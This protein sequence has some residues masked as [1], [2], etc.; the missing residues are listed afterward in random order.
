MSHF[1]LSLLTLPPAASCSSDVSFRFRTGLWHILSWPGVVQC[2]PRTPCILA[3]VQQT[4]E[5]EENWIKALLTR[6]QEGVENPPSGNI[7][8]GHWSWPTAG[9]GKG[10]EPLAELGDRKSQ[11]NELWLL[12]HG[13]KTLG[14]QFLRGSWKPG[15]LSSVFFLS[16][17]P[18]LQVLVFGWTLREATG[19]GGSLMQS[20]LVSPSGH[21]V[22]K[23]KC[24]LG[25]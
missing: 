11:L 6:V 15:L 19:Q 20:K 18:S 16:F 25:E 2:Y 8:V 12:E 17:F 23:G 21:R 4:W 1:P 5:F 7:L 22:G 24:G 10:R 3:K 9:T 14:W 13:S